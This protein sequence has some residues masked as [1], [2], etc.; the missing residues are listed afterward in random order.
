MGKP[1]SP[2]IEVDVKFFNYQWIG[3]DIIIT[4][5]GVL[6]KMKILFLSLLVA[7]LLV[8][9]SQTG[10]AIVDKSL[11]LYLPCDETLKDLSGKGNH[12]VEGQG[13]PKWEDGKFAKALLIEQ[14]GFVEIDHD[15]S[16][17]LEG[18]H[19]ISFWLKWDGVGSSWSPFIA[20]RQAD[21]A[22]YQSWVGSDR[23]FD[24]YNGI[25]VVSAAT[26]ISLGEEWVFLTTTH[27]GKNTVSF[28]INGSF[29]SS[30]TAEIGKS[31]NFPLLVGQDG[32]G[33]FGAGAIDEVAIFNRALTEV[34]IKKL[35]EE[36]VKA[37]AALASSGKL[38][39]TWGSIKN[40][41]KNP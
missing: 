11:V 6:Q 16:L 3:Q 23:I 20:K 41:S 31:N 33:N 38:T 5:Q 10:K 35:V 24:Y 19:T 30:K 4:R 14:G 32:V 2:V 36:G 1:Q 17:N 21:G 13:K 40:Q 25:A 9:F 34:E 7:S 22:N 15:S 28:Y 29:D 27:D 18:A 37:F 12:G 8:M 39:I 26:P